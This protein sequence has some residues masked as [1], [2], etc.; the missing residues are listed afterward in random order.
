MG[1]TGGRSIP[2]V[3]ADEALA[4]LDELKDQSILRGLR[5]RAPVDVNRFARLIADLSQWSAAAPWLGELD[6][7]PIVANG[8][9]FT[10]VDARMRIATCR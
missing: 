6:L 4:M 3:E 1:V 10:I 7:N 2:P 8:D 9:G 5:G